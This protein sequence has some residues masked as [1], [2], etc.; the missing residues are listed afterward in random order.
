ML[1]AKKKGYALPI[2]FL[3]NWMR[4]QQNEARQWRN[5]RSHYNSSLTQAYRLYTLAL[6]GQP[7]LAAMNRLRESGEMSNDAKWR[8]AAA[9]AL[10]GKESVAQQITS[11][12]NI[13][14]QSK[15]YNS[16][17]SVFIRHFS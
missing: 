13:S 6:A 11:T 16:F 9:Y 15:D 4:Y 8:L 1:E 2:T 17:T 5:S 7:E 3:S 12:A 10:I 14:F